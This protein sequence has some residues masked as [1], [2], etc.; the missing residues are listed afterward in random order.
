M[1]TKI[2]EWFMSEF[3]EWLLMEFLPFCAEGIVKGFLLLVSVFVAILMFPLAVIR[4][5]L[6]NYNLKLISLLASLSAPSVTFGLFKQWLITLNLDATLSWLHTTDAGAIVFYLLISGAYWAMFYL[7][8][9]GYLILEAAYE[10]SL[11]LI[12]IS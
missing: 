9:R 11:D 4:S 3:K 2:K 1:Q 10:D 8:G 5:L 7:I 12:D 6:S